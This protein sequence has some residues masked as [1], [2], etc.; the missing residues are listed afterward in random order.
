MVAKD[1]GSWHTLDLQR[2][3]V[4]AL[5]KG[6]VV[7]FRGMEMGWDT[8]ARRGYNIPFKPH[9]ATWTWVSGPKGLRLTNMGVFITDLDPAWALDSTGRMILD[10]DFMARGGIAKTINRLFGK[11]I[12]RHGTHWQGM[13]QGEPGAV[14]SNN[15][16]NYVNATVFVYG[17]EIMG[18]TGLIDS[19]PA[20]E[21]YKKYRRLLHD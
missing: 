16:E 2:A 14:A 1:R 12:V 4:Q 6:E 18:K 7:A 20:L 5:D 15:G 8:W 19:G 11:E 13:I 10:A 21:M 3:I 17:K 9:E